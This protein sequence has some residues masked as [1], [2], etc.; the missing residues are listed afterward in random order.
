MRLCAGGCSFRLL[1]QGGLLLACILFR[2][3][4]EKKG[5]EALGA[6]ACA[7][8]AALPAYYAVDA[9]VSIAGDH[10]F[11]SEFGGA[12]AVGSAGDPWAAEGVEH[13]FATAMQR[14]S[15]APVALGR[16]RAIGHRAW[17]A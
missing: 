4:T 15:G 9:P 2:V 13:S 5:V 1:A 6:L 10:I 12:V 17:G 16:N 7:L 8:V 11:A 14:V 3:E